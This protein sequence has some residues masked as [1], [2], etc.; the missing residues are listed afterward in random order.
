MDTWATSA[1]TPQVVS[2]W[3]L[4]TS[5]HE[6]LFPTDLR[7]QSHELIRTWAFYSIAKALMHHNE[8]P[9]KHV[10]ISGWIL[11]PDR[12]KMS[13]SK[14]NVVTPMTFIEKYSSDA[15]R[16]WAARA[17]L[18]VDTAFDEKVLDIGRK[19]VT[20]ISNASR[21]V[22][23]QL[24]ESAQA[25]VRHSFED[26]TMPIDRAW[27]GRI[28]RGVAEATKCYE[29]LDHAGAL[30]V[31]ET[32]FWDFC[33]NYLELVK[34]RCYGGTAEEK[35]S[36]F[37]A[38]SGS[39]SVFLRMF[40]P[41]LPYVTEEM[42]QQIRRSETFSSIHV[43]PWP[44]RDPGMEQSIED[45]AAYTTAL[46]IVSE[47]RRVK[48]EAKKAVGWPVSSAEITADKKT[49]QVVEQVLSDVARAMNVSTA[50]ITLTHMP[51]EASCGSVKVTVQLA[52]E[53]VPG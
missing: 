38:L 47:S 19:L 16:Y 1:L 53:R 4:P 48:G 7:P 30:M 5:K 46:A 8:I 52:A 43:A 29:S 42:W 36:A 20:K 18:G 15:V 31:G 14:G 10:A 2:H 25:G 40:A 37:G 17:K 24:E 45:D 41:F 27:V 44:S 28:R 50:A 32:T 35:R 26:A 23:M 6:K 3:G 11:D 34:A 21:F 51:V 49:L 13:K 9:W 12:K 33:D 39:L 22:I